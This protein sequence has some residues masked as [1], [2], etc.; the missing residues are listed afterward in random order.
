L[1]PI[2]TAIDSSAPAITD[3]VIGSTRVAAGALIG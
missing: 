3:A 2:S 1:W